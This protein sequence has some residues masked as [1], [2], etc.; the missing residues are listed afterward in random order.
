MDVNYLCETKG[1][2]FESYIRDRGCTLLR[3]IILGRNGH[4][5]FPD[6]LWWSNLDVFMVSMKFNN[7]L[8]FT[9]KAS[10]TNDI[11]LVM[12]KIM[13]QLTLK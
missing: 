5:V 12:I 11:H 9:L 8:N 6:F 1:L 13:K 4:P 3:S 7:R 10:F 2:V